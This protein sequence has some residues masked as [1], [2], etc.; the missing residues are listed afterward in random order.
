MPLKSP[1]EP[2]VRL[3]FWG[4]TR[5]FGKLQNPCLPNVRSWNKGFPPRNVQLCF[6]S[7][8]SSFC[9]TKNQKSTDSCQSNPR[10]GMGLRPSSSPKRLKS[11]QLLVGVLFDDFTPKRSFS[12]KNGIKSRKWKQKI[13]KS[14]LYPFRKWRVRHS[15]ANCSPTGCWKCP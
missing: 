13:K 10:C 8:R 12:C 14:T 1:V 7:E 3:Q 9:S 11:A 5:T 6:S 15:G 2:P 4:K